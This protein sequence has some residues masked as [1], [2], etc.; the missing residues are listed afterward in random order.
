MSASIESRFAKK[1]PKVQKAAT[2]VKE[3]LTMRLDDPAALP[4]VALLVGAR[5]GDSLEPR[6]GW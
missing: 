5:V 4:A 3:Y 2:G 1:F 6:Y